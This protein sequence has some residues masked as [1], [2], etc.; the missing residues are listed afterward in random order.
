MRDGQKSADLKR[1][2]EEVRFSVRHNSNG[3]QV[4]KA[5]RHSNWR[6]LF[7]DHVCPLRFNDFEVEKE[8]WLFVTLCVT[9]KVNLARAVELQHKRQTKPVFLPK[10]IKF[11]GAAQ[12]PGH[13]E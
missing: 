12:N 2:L 10:H 11:Y 8:K 1:R 5:R 3:S 7:D 4:S 13:P 6:Q 9:F